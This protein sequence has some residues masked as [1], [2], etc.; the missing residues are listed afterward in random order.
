MSTRDAKP[1]KS[2]NDTDFAEKLQRISGTNS[3]TDISL[4]YLRKIELNYW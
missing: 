2:G 1:K 3:G 4:V